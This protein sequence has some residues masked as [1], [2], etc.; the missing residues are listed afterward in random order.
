LFT[1]LQVL[2]QEGDVAATL[3]DSWNENCGASHEATA[4]DMWPCCQI[5]AESWLIIGQ[6]E[7]LAAISIGPFKIATAKNENAVRDFL[8][9]LFPATVA[10]L[11]ATSVLS[12]AVNGVLTGTC[13]L[14]VKLLDRGVIFGRS[15]E[16]RQRWAIL[17]YIA[18]CNTDSIYPE[19]GSLIKN[20]ALTI[21]DS[22][23]TGN[24]NEAIDWLFARGL[25]AFSQHSAGG[26][27]ARI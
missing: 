21:N 6:Q 7:D 9:A 22:A 8:E 27:E 2:G 23:S 14:F 17:A 13:L 12:S 10:S 15:L 26:L 5:L 16:D 18:N 24:T 3:A 19:R 25:I 1:V 4:V 11:P 20:P